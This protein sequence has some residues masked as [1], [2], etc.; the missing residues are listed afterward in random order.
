MATIVQSYVGA[1]ASSNIYF[2]PIT[3]PGMYMAEN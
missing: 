3:D 1:G 2:L